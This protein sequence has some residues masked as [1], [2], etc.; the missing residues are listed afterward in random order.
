LKTLKPKWPKRFFNGFRGKNSAQT[1]QNRLWFN[2]I[3][4]LKDKGNRALAA[5]LVRKM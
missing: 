4:I 3:P 2:L 1:R 5:T